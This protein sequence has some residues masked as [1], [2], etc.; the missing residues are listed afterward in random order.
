MPERIRIYYEGDDDRN[1]LEQLKAGDLLSPVL[2]IASRDKKRAG[3]EGLVQELAPF[4]RPVNGVGGSAIA[5]V[6]LDDRSPEALASWFQKELAK[7]IPS[8]D[9]AVSVAVKL[10]KSASVTVFELS[11]G[12]RISHVACVAV[13]LPEDEEL[14][15]DYEITRH[16]IDDYLFRVVRD[17]SA[18]QAISDFQDV[19][20]AKAMTKIRE[21]TELLRSND[22]PV[23]NSK[24]L[25]HLLRAV[26]NF[27]PSSAEFV[28]RVVGKVL[29]KLDG[30]KVKALFQPLLTD[31]ELAVGAL[32]AVQ[33]R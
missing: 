26:V 30:A 33:T 2:E 29:D 19:D 17:V 21:M 20:Y 5:L 11:A 3:Q 25:L 7:N 28:K 32:T 27:R 23:E 18:Y 14:V 12:E 6:D 9:P 16:A 10:S 1:A 24:R 22:I 13:E 31:L 4:I 15:K 8:S